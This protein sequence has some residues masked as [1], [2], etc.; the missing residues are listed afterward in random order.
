VG[1]NKYKEIFPSDEPSI[2][3]VLFYKMY[4]TYKYIV[5]K[6]SSFAVDDYGNFMVHEINRVLTEG[7]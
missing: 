6:D 4:P 3:A 1:A 2:S 5:S 7:E